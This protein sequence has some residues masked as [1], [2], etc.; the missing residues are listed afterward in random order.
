LQPN[1]GRS[2]GGRAPQP[3]PQS[4]APPGHHRPRRSVEPSRP[5]DSSA[6][7]SSLQQ[8]ASRSSYQRTSFSGRAA[9]SFES[10]PLA[11]PSPHLDRRPR[12]WW[13]VLLPLAAL[14]VAASLLLPAGR[15]E[16]A[17]SLI[18]QPTP[19]TALS[20]DRSWALPAT[21]KAGQPIAFTFTIDNEQGRPISYRYVV[22]QT[23]GDASETFGEAAKLV[24]P[25][26]KWTVSKTVRLTCATGLSC[27]VTVHLPGHPEM[28]DFLVT[29]EP[30]RKSRA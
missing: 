30:P 8:P 21:A 27:R 26:A 11:Q 5:A 9:G 6:R 18:R 2:R 19:F 7:G 3:D 4:I 15:H 24:Q 10:A 12:R 20:F 25:G 28:I 22:T 13:P 23:A 16:W 17:L 29:I 14:A 1:L